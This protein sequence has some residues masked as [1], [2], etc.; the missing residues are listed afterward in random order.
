MGPANHGEPTLARSSDWLKV[1]AAWNEQINIPAE[2][3]TNKDAQAGS[4][5]TVGD[6][7]AAV[8]AR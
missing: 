1:R 6:L 4:A 8:T 5:I 7:H 2:T 3:N